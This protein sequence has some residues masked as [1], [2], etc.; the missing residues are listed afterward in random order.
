MLVIDI[1][2]LLL[3]VSFRAAQSSIVESFILF[4]AYNIFL[5]ELA[6]TF[7]EHLKVRTNY[8]I[9]SLE[10]RQYDFICNKEDPPYQ[11]VIRTDDDTRF[12]ADRCSYRFVKLTEDQADEIMK[13]QTGLD[14]RQQ[15]GFG[16]GG[17][18]KAT[19]LMFVVQ[20]F[21]EGGS[22]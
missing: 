3:H 18:T 2:I 17:I 13:Q 10:G 5:S 16:D 4:L 14:I 12:F 19:T 22:K 21:N 9:Y 11:M 15:P 6:S 7:H 8:F 1:F 20:I